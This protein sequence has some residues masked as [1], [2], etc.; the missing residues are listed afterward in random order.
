VRLESDPLGDSGFRSLHVAL[1]AECCLEPKMN[2]PIP[3][4]SGARSGE[5][6]YG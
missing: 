4:I 6:I 5:Q 1:K 2:V 3:K